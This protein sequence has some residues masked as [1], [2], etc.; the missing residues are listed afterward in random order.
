MQI[1]AYFDHMLMTMVPT[2]PTLH[3]SVPRSRISYTQRKADASG[4]H[5]KDPFV[6]ESDNEPSHWVDSHWEGALNIDALLMVQTLF[7]S[8]ITHYLCAS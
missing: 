7:D 3:P 4:V 8:K 1:I 6:V 5:F 2:L